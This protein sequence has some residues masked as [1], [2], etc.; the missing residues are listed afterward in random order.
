MNSMAH[1]ES[2][3]TGTGALGEKHCRCALACVACGTTD[4][5]DGATWVAETVALLVPV[6]ALPSDA[7]AIGLMRVTQGMLA[8]S[9]I[10]RTHADSPP[11]PNEEFVCPTAT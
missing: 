11:V 10:F 6:V 4:V 2:A 7:V 8:G 3:G 5:S 1:S 9:S